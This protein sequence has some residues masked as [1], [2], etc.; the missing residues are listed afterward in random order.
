MDGLSKG[1]V[2]IDM[3]KIPENLELKYKDWPSYHMKALLESGCEVSILVIFHVSKSAINDDF[4]SSEI[5]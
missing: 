2:Y 4:N 3:K 5:K 1:D